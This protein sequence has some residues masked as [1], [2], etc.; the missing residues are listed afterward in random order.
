[1]FF[2]IWIYLQSTSANILQTVCLLLFAETNRLIIDFW[3]TMNQKSFL[4]LIQFCSILI[5]SISADEHL[6]SSVIFSDCKHLILPQRCQCYHSA[7][8]SQLRCHNIQLY[9]LPKL[10]NN[11]RWFAL[12]FSLNNITSIESYAFSEIYVEKLYFHSNLLNRIDPTGFNFIENLKELYLNQNRLTQFSG[13][14]LLYPGI[15]LGKSDFVSSILIDRKREKQKKKTSRFDSVFDFS[16][17]TNKKRKCFS[18]LVLIDKSKCSVEKSSEKLISRR[19]RRSTKFTIFTVQWIVA[20]TNC[21]SRTWDWYS[22][23]CRQSRILWTN[24]F[25]DDRFSWC[26]CFICLNESVQCEPMTC[27]RMNR[28]CQLSADKTNKTMKTSRNPFVCRKT[29]TDSYHWGKPNGR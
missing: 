24:S 5:R 4:L 15:Q 12:D 7:D 6:L 22:S 27:S 28:F 11:M 20:S 8:Q 3:S 1:M 23:A 29:R 18:R 10:P 26:F 19:V 17:E 13:E 16:P 14:L 25:D 2:L 21:L 9:D